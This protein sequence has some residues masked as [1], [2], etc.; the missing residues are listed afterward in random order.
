M[1]WQQKGANY[2]YGSAASRDANVKLFITLGSPYARMARITVHEKQ[3]ESLVEVIVVQTRRSN[4]PYYAINPSGRVPSDSRG[5][6][7]VGAVLLSSAPG[8]T[9][10]EANRCSISR[11]VTR[12]DRAASRSLGQKHDGWP[13]G[14]APRNRRPEGERSPSVIRHEAERASRMADLRKSEIEPPWV[15][16]ALNLAQITLG[17]ALGLEARNPDFHWRPGR[18]KLCD[19]FDRIAARPSFVATAPQPGH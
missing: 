2:R 19:W 16:G 14:L 4:S 5:W 8:S 1:L 6:R 15:C 18:A 12:M 10:L 13:F 9:A 17:C 7:R 11:R 3:L